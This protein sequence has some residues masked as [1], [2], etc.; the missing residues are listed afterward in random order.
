MADGPEKIGTRLLLDVGDSL[1][2]QFASGEKEERHYIRLVG[3][4]PG[5]TL[6]EICGLAVSF[7][8]ML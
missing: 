8:E 5:I 1:Q 3:Y 7:T 4:M 6:H 2:L